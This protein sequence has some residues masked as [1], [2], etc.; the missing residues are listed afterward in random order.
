MALTFAASLTLGEAGVAEVMKYF[1]DNA[2]GIEVIDVQNDPFF[3]GVDVDLVLVHKQLRQ[4]RWVEVKSDTY[5]SGKM[6][7]ETWSNLERQSP[8]CLMYTRADFLVHY[9]TAY[10]WAI[11]VPVKALREWMGRR[12]EEFPRKTTTNTLSDGA[13]FT[14]VG[15]VVPVGVIQSEVRGTSILWG[16]RVFER[17]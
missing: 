13:T 14:S 7:L 11:M 9:F 15:H 1:T 5:T 17:N 12:V 8:G 3:Q 2:P 6:F 4:V 10:G 16:L